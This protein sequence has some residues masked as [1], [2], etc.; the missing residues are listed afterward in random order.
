MLSSYQAAGVPSSPSAAGI[1]AHTPLLTHTSY[2]STF[3]HSYHT[4][5]HHH[6]RG[7]RV[8]SYSQPLSVIASTVIAATFL[9]V[10]RVPLSDA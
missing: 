2:T 9:W 3:T 10:S 4:H 1:H 6:D 7:R 8:Q 5:T